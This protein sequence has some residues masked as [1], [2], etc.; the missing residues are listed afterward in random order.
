NYFL[1]HAKLTEKIEYD[2]NVLL[3]DVHLYELNQFDWPYFETIR[4]RACPHLTPFS[5]NYIEQISKKQ[6]DR[7]INA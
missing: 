2:A 1:E 4:I 5:M 7:Q 6:I 3:T